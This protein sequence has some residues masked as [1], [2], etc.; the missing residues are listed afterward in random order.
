MDP[1][2]SLIDISF[3]QMLQF[4]TNAHIIVACPKTTLLYHIIELATVEFSYRI[5][6]AFFDD[7]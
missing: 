4:E 5:T 2:D 7:P 6:H 1:R 3:K